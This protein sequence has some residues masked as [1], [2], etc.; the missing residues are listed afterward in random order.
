MRSYFHLITLFVCKRVEKKNQNKLVLNYLIENMSN[1]VRPINKLQ[2]KMENRQAISVR[3]SFR[4]RS[5]IFVCPAFL[6]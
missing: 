1:S 6:M 3:H 5:N 2:P 4:R